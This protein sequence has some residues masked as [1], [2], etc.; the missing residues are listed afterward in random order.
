MTIADF[1]TEL[2]CTIDDQ[3]KDMLII[4]SRRCIYR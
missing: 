3:M 4:A 2:F 1:I